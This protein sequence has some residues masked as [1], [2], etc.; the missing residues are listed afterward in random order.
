MKEGEVKEGRMLKLGV[1][2]YFVNNCSY[3]HK[4]IHLLYIHAKHNIFSINTLSEK[5]SKRSLI[6]TLNLHIKITGL[7]YFINWL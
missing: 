4:E 7:E 5:S 2:N 3:W 1:S 6:L